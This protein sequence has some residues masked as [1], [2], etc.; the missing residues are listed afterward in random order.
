MANTATLKSTTIPNLPVTT[1]PQ[2]NDFLIIEHT[3]PGSNTS[4]TS[5][6]TTNNFLNQLSINQ[7][8]TEYIATSN[9]VV[10]STKGTPANSTSSNVVTNSIWFDSDYIYVAVGNN[11]V[12]RALLS[13]F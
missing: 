6:I 9:L 7:S 5:K 1:N 3:P 11:V 2:L 13:S 4:V 10:S 12:K 8:N